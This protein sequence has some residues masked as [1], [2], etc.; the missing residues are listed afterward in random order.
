MTVRRLKGGGAAVVHCRGKKKGKVIKKHPTL[1]AALKQ[2]AAIQINKKK[3]R[4][5]RRVA[6]P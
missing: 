4:G 5:G 1:A 2:H 6:R 3:R